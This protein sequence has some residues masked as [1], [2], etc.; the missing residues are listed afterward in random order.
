MKQWLVRSLRAATPYFIFLMIFACMLEMLFYFR[1]KLEN[2][3][4]TPVML[5]MIGTAITAIFAIWRL[6]MS[7][8]PT[9]LV[10]ESEAKGY[11]DI[12]EDVDTRTLP[13]QL[14]EY[15]RRMRRLALSYERQR[16]NLTVGGVIVATLLLAVPVSTWGVIL[17][18][19]FSKRET[20]PN[21]WL[22]VVSS[23]ATG[24][25]GLA[26][27]V[28]MLRHVKN[29]QRP[30]AEIQERMFDALEAGIALNASDINGE[31][32]AKSVDNV[33]KTLSLL[34]GRRAMDDAEE[35]E[36]SENK[37]FLDL[38][39]AGIKSGVKH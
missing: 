5:L 11:F 10:T 13:M 12:E 31:Q 36:E 9:S 38:L 23:T 14:L 27:A 24:G 32:R 20:L 33:L 37:I 39:M 21:A 17:A 19:A 29:N 3:I 22:L 34:R 1:N 4:L 35:S 30:L 8:S 7:F 26:I 16:L 6:A 25:L 28:T 15:R 2:P 18:Q